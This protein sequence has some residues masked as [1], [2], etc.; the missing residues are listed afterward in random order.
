MTAT[1]GVVRGEKRESPLTASGNLFSR[2][3]SYRKPFS[4]F[5]AG[6]ADKTLVILSAMTIANKG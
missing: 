3:G 6:I 4:L 1:L 2:S 5:L